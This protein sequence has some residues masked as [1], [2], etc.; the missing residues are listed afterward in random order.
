ML[1][2]KG[3]KAEFWGLQVD[4]GTVLP[5]LVFQIRVTNDS[6]KARLMILCC[7][8]LAKCMPDSSHVFNL[9]QM[10]TM[11]QGYGLAP[12][13]SA[14]FS[15]NMTLTPRMSEIIEEYRGKNDLGLEISLGILYSNQES[16]DI[17]IDRLHVTQEGSTRILIPRSKWRDL[18][19][20]LGH[21]ETFVLEVPVTPI[22]G[23]APL[24]EA[25][26]FLRKADAKFIE[27]EDMGAVVT[28]CRQALEKISQTIGSGAVN[29]EKLFGEES[30]ASQFPNLK[31]HQYWSYKVKQEVETIR[32][33]CGPG[34]HIEL[35]TTR[36]EAKYALV[37]T[38]AILSYLALMLRTQE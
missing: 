30:I 5:T 12:G 38:A 2:D 18:L 21:Q 15:T 9:G 35:Q 28:N 37:H 14:D 26:D 23:I 22:V 13:G 24:A 17:G 34:P 25:L 6:D 11:I 10:N 20:E 31:T 27:G 3:M 8:A 7:Q 16:H 29:L 4:A 36:R 32:G 19:D 1:L 33:F